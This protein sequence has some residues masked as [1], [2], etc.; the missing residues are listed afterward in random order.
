MQLAGARVRYQVWGDGEPLV[1]VHGLAGSTAWW[2]RN[3]GVFSR[4][5]TVYLVDLPGFGVMRRY[6]RQFS[7]QGAVTWLRDL[8]DAL[9]VRKVS[10]VGHSMGGLITAL[11][12]AQWPDRLTAIVLAA[13]AI[14][15]AHKSVM[16]FLPSLGRE[17]L[18][19][20]PGFV[21]TLLW[22]TARAGLFT[23]LR[24]SREMLSMDIHNELGQIRTPCLLVWGE[25]DPLIPVELS[26]GVQ[27]E[28]HGSRLCV[29]PGAG[30]IVMYD[31]AGQFNATVLDFLGDRAL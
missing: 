3:V 10:M 28:I 30:H 17:A 26:H 23:L 11:F 13:P 29:L 7:I 14:A 16:P 20:R 12:A 2:V 24:A 6:A 18:L 8:L 5:Y 15:F 1:L 4:H 22:D 31:Q 19:L 27:A 9:D 25:R 21:P